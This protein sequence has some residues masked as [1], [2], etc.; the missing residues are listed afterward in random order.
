MKMKMATQTTGTTDLSNV[1]VELGVDVRRTNGREI[2]GCCPVH[3][4]RTGRADGSP[5][6]SMN[7]E[8]GLW[9]CHS[10]GARG[11]LAGL[12]SELTGNPDSVSAVN[13]LLIE[14]GINRLT[15]PERVE[16][17]PD[18]DWVSYS[19]FSLVPH[20][21]LVQRHLDADVALAHGIKWN[22]L[23]KAWVI[24]IVS[25]FGELMGWQE[26]GYN[27]FNNNPTGVKKSH[28]LFGIER[29]QSRTAVLVESPLDVVRFASSFGGIQ[30]LATVGAHVSKEQMQLVTDVAERVIIAMDNDK[31]GIESAK[32]LLKNLPRFRDGIFFLNYDKTDAKDIGDMTDEQV[33]HAVTTASVVPWWLQ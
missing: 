26:K 16:F 10:C 14:T 25:P 8:S 5:S 22:M 13:Q 4:K 28:T 9:I 2:S 19:R 33:N 6:W 27:Y 29:F 18:V 3:E 7:A 12:V 20:R 21:E 31:A 24:P 11:T 15:A 23:K 32:F 30:A 1:L 17:Q